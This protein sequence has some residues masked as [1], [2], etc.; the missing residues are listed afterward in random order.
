MR[1]ALVLLMTLGFLAAEPAKEDPGRKDLEKMQ[2]DWASV[3]M[4]KDGFQLEADDAQAYFR[5]VKGDQFTVFRYEKPVSKGTF[6]L[7]ATKKPKEMD[8]Q[9]AA[10]GKSLSV[11][12]LYEVEGDTLRLCFA[13]P[14]KDRPKAFEAKEGSGHTLTVWAREKK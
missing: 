13:A 3:S 8:V 14:G 7:D 2:G 4:T 5:T 12:G 11:L 9:V 10:G 1:P 6:K